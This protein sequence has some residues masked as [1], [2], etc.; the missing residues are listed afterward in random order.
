MSAGVFVNTR[1]EASYAAATYHNIRVQPETLLADVAG[2]VNDAPT[3]LVNNPISAVVSGS[4]RT[5][6]LTP[7]KIRLKLPPGTT[8]PTG[9]KPEGTTTIPILTR[10]L[11]DLCQIGGT[12]TYLGA[13]WRIQDTLPEK[14]R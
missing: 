12:C 6:G 14:A 3:Q 1:Y 9:Y 2:T 4:N 5:L 8:P 7:R 13:V 11:F 10:A